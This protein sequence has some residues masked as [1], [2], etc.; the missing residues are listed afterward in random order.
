MSA[1][2]SGSWHQGLSRRGVLGALPLVAT[3]GLTSCSWTRSVHDPDNSTSPNAVDDALRESVAQFEQGLLIAYDR[4]IL[5][6]PSIAATLAVLRAHHA[7]HAGRLGSPP[8]GT[9]LPRAPRSPGSPAEGS[10]AAGSTVAGFAAGPATAAP[11]LPGPATDRAASQQATV[12]ALVRLEQQ[13]AALLRA[14]CL[15]AAAGLAPLLASIHAAELA[16]ADLLAPL[17]R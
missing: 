10:P 9:G 2:G 6:H 4:A 16:H 12:A 5:A 11:V 17:A 13:A 15:V 7:E 1:T 14:K 3:A 8:T